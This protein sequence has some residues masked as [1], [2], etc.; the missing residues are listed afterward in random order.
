M[1]KLGIIKHP[2]GSSK[3]SDRSVN[4]FNG[5]C[6]NCFLNCGMNRNL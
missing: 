1:A 6:E 2:V 3:N 5:V 4:S